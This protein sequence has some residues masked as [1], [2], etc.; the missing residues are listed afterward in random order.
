M[1]GVVFTAR[2]VFFFSSGSGPLLFAAITFC[3]SQLELV[4]I[5]TLYPLLFFAYGGENDHQWHLMMIFVRSFS[6]IEYQEIADFHYLRGLC[7]SYNT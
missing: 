4:S 7:V 2:V 6:L 5:R 1:W 3:H